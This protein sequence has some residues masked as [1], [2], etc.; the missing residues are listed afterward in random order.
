MTKGTLNKIS[1]VFY[2]NL[3]RREDRREH[4]EETLNFKAER[5]RAVDSKSIELD[6]EI[7][8]LFPSNY[9]KLKKSEIACCLSHYALWQKLASD[10]DAE[11]YLSAGAD[12]ISLG[13]VSFTPWKIKGIIND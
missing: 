2:I 8:K 9:H 5:F 11:N 4:L 6:E 7:R 12:H 3:D 10:K 1:K 13:S